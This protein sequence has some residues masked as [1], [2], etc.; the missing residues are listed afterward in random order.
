MKQKDNLTTG[1]N[2]GTSV[3][4]TGHNAKSHD[5]DFAKFAATPHIGKTGY[6]AR[7]GQMDTNDIVDVVRFSDRLGDQVGA[8]WCSIISS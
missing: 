6:I 5:P 1:I 4:I 7:Q 3:T 2:P 8:N